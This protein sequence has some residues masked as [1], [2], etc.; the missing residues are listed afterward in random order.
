MKFAVSQGDSFNSVRLLVGHWHVAFLY[1]VIY[2]E[3]PERVWIVAVMH[4][5]RRPEY[6]HERLGDAQRKAASGE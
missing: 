2:L 5:K 6:W 4:A 3:E 1:S